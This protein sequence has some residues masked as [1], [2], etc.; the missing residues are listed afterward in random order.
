ML[1]HLSAQDV[2]IKQNGGEHKTPLVVV[3]VI[4]VV[5]VLTLTLCYL[6]AAFFCSANM[7]DNRYHTSIQFSYT[8]GT[9]TLYTIP[10]VFTLFTLHFVPGM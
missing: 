4:V 7:Y 8:S 1:V 9:F 5:A 3:V 2:K 6:V 10:A